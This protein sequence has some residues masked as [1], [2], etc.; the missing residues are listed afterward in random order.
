MNRSAWIRILTAVCLL[1]LHASAALADAIN[2]AV[3]SNFA[4]PIKTLASRFESESGHQINLVFGSTGK[5]YAQIKSGAPFAA[6][7]AAD[8]RRPE[9]LE[10]EDIARPGSRFTYAV[11]R[12][13]L[14]SPQKD[15][16]D[17]QGK[18]LEAKTFQHLAIANP[19]LAPYG[20][21]A[22]QF[23][24]ERGLWDELKNRMV[25]GEN[26]GQTFQFVRSGSA[27][28]GFVAYSQVKRPGHPQEGSLWEVP[29]FTYAP[30]EQQAVL[31]QDNPV[32]KDFLAYIKSPEAV[33]IIRGYGYGMP[34]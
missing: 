14:W 33:A 22:Q 7:F 30:I 24:Q 8:S 3:A 34:V 17:S 6:F 16:V 27:E 32:A 5:H 4:E 2:I 20:K 25:R 28:L 19:K 10:K 12:I 11:G 29:E 1:V 31:L 9:L 23:L 26:I 15:L 18:V 21:A 13:V